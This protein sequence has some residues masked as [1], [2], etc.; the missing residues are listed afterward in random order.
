MPYPTATPQDIETFQAHGW[1]AIDDAI[2]P[3]DLGT[4]E[5]HRDEILE[6]METMAFD[7]AWEKGKSLAER[8]FRLVQASPT[9][10]WPELNEARFRSWA[11]AFAF[12]LMGKPLE[13]WYDQFLAKPP[14]IG[15]P[16][17]WHQ[18]EGYWGQVGRAHV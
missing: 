17:L 14:E 5:A 18:D 1:I 7:W 13:F 10:Y 12:A 6:K 15:A 2:D 3:A 9:L 8:D 4:L 16:T 11:I